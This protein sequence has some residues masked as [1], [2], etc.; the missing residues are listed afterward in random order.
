MIAT[1]P[2]LLI[3][4]HLSQSGFTEALTFI[5]I[6]LLY[7]NLYVMR[8]LVKSYGV[9]STFTLSPGKIFMKFFLIF[10]EM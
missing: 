3:T 6:F 7:F 8:P 1:L 10:P 4:L 5:S 9:I 2:F